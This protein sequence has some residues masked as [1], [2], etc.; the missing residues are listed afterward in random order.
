[1]STTGSEIFRVIQGSNEP[2]AVSD[3]VTALPAAAREAVEKTVQELIAKGKIFQWPNG[4]VWSS[5]KEDE[6]DFYLGKARELI[7]DTPLWKSA[8]AEKL[9]SVVPGASKKVCDG[10]FDRLK[11][12]PGVHLWP[13]HRHLKGDSICL[14]PVDLSFYLAGA[15]EEFGD[16]YKKLCKA[17]VAA[18]DLVGYVCEDA[19]AAV[20]SATNG[21]S[22]AKPPSASSSG[23][24]DTESDRD[25]QRDV[26]DHL[27]FAWQDAKTAET[28]L[29]LERVMF[30][31]GLRRLGES[32]GV[33][34][35]NGLEHD[36]K[37]RLFPGDKAKVVEPGWMLLRGP[38]KKVLAKALVQ[39]L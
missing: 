23:E 22:Q 36:T 16:S 33:V 17:G 27:V 39:A 5:W 8:L 11:S 9:A 19:M 3:I 32:E 24:P 30:N 26:T 34:P 38:K 29:Q 37:D 31:I 21:H 35:F 10:A 1:M 12:E 4:K 14:K 18:L 6:S 2:V 15:R 25:Y 28:R 20:T 13:R 7:R